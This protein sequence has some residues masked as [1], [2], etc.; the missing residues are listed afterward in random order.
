MVASFSCTLKG[1]ADTF[2][3]RKAARIALI[4]YSEIFYNRQRRHTSIGGRA[5]A[6]VRHVGR[7]VTRLAVES[8]VA[9]GKR[10]PYS[11]HSP[12]DDWLFL[13]STKTGQ[14]RVPH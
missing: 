9:A 6:A 4:D 12:G 13:V 11:S 1:D 8:D 2:S 7:G 3:S 5:R 10:G 14:V